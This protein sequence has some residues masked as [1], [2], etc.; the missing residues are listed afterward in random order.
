MG[1]WG[2]GLYANDDAQD[3]KG[4]FADVFS[5][6]SPEEGTKILVDEYV[7]DMDDEL[8]SDFWFALADWQWNKGIL[9]D[10]VKQKALK[11]LDSGVGLELWLE[12]GNKSDIAKRKQVLEDLRTKLNSPLPEAKKIRSG[13]THSRYKPGDIIAIKPNEKLK[14]VDSGYDYWN[15]YPYFVPENIKAELLSMY[16]NSKIKL[17][18]PESGYQPVINADSYFLIL[19]VRNERSYSSR[20]TE[21]YDEYSYFAPLDYYSPTLDNL[22]NVLDNLNIFKTFSNYDND[23]IYDTTYCVGELGF[24]NSKK[25]ANSQNLLEKFKAIE[26]EN[27]IK[28]NLHYKCFLETYEILN[29]PQIKWTIEK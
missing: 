18:F 26:S 8:T 11:L 9:L 2:T 20:F 7:G 1:T 4:D 14:Y 10:S 6:K 28:C 27:R 19:C 12:E 29:N 21:L 3:A 24:S 22:E 15:E 13:R 16:K 5:I 23:L 25:L 17:Q